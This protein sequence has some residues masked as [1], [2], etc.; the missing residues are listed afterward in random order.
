[1]N[2]LSRQ[3]VADFTDEGLQKLYAE[4]ESKSVTAVIDF[5]DDFM[6]E[7]EFGHLPIGLT[8][9]WVETHQDVRLKEGDVSIW[10]GING[11]RK[12]TLVSQVLLHAALDA[13]VGIM[14]FE[15]SLGKVAAML[16]RQAAASDEPAT[17]FIERFS[18][19]SLGALW[20]YRCLGGAEPTQVLGA[21]RA[22]AAQGCKF[23]VI[24]N[25]QFCRVTDDSER[26]RRFM[27]ALV[28]IASA[29]NIHIGLVHHVRK[30]P[31]GGDEYIPTKFDVR[32]S[33]S[34]TDQ[35]SQVFIIWHNK[36]RAKIK[37]AMEHG[38]PLSDR[39]REVLDT[40]PDQ[41][42]IVAKQRHLPFEGTISLYDGKGR[43]FKKREKDKGLHLNFPM[44]HDSKI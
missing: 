23:I 12:S 27:N 40:Q 14:S 28:S 17:E 6:N 4:H 20:F 22:M 39:D 32:G 11:H 7:M 13:P 9:P 16:C 34:I 29:L 3:V 38:A 15:M 18:A 37:N 42:L 21:I 33:G 30:P 8:L 26:E 43:T 19:W 5:Y 41:R 36:R 1:M 44:A 31:T 2:N 25:L 35:A 24:D 10:C